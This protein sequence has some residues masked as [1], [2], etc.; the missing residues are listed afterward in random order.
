MNIKR[1]LVILGVVIITAGILFVMG[2][3]ME[4]N[5]IKEKQEAEKYNEWLAENCECLKKDRYF[6]REG[7]ELKE[8]LCVNEAEKLYTYRLIGCSEYDCSGEIKL[9]N[10]ETERWG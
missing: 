4:A 8:N 10:N 6:C 2:S 9:W 1:I 3:Y 7:F 5:A